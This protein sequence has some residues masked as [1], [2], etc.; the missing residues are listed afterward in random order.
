[1]LQKLFSLLTVFHKKKLEGKEIT[2]F[3][4]YGFSHV[5][6]GNES[7]TV[8]RARALLCKAVAPVPGPVR[9]LAGFYRR[10]LH[11]GACC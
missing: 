10:C 9:G 7:A 11:T 5:I 8:S 4:I 2:C 3:M 1:M 6:L